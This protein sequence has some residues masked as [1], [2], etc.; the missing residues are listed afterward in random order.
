MQY[1][2]CGYK[3]VAKIHN[4]GKISNKVPKICALNSKHVIFYQLNNGPP[5]AGQTMRLHHFK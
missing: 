3:S 2:E 4:G 1:F 5:S